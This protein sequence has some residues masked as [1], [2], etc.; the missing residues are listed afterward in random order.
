ML[1]IRHTMHH[2]QTEHPKA[3]NNLFKHPWVNLPPGG[4]LLNAVPA[5]LQ[6][7]AGEKRM[8][9]FAVIIKFEQLQHHIIQ[10]YQVNQH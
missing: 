5:M 7:D 9:L 10:N 6:G 3:L 4:Y 2:D 8:K 1:R